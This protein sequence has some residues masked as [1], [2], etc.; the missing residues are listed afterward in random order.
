MA[1]LLGHESVDTTRV[2]ATPSEQDLRRDVKKIPPVAV[3][4]Q[5]RNRQP[6]SP[7]PQSCAGPYSDYQ[8]TFKGAPAPALMQWN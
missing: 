4:W 5:K 3:T 8:E 1:Q 2:Y 7:Q 6:S